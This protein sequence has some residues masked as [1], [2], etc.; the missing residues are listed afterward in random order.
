MASRPFTATPMLAALAIVLSLLVATYVGGYLWLGERI[1]IA[2]GICIRSYPRPWLDELFKPA[3]QT[4]S[5]LLG[6]YV[7]VGGVVG[8]PGNPPKDH[9][10]VMPRL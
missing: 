4:E 6:T 3:A 10:A 8:L 9:P 1:D 5:W 2:Q 7:E